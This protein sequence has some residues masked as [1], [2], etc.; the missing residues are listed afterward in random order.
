MRAI[1]LK[2]EFSIRMWLLMLQSKG[3]IETTESG[4]VLTAKGNAKI[5]NLNNPVTH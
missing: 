3:L 5:E 1:G 2:N 4:Y